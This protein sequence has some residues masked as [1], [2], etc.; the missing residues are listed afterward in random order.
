MYG[1]Q[2]PN[3]QVGGDVSAQKV[4]LHLPWQLLENSH[5]ENLQMLA[6]K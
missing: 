2:V 3:S 1:K 6:E 4:V 5:L